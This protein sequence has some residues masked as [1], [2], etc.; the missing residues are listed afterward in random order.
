MTLP[1]TIAG[2]AF[3]SDSAFRQVVAAIAVEGDLVLAVGGAVRNAL[4]GLPVADVD[5]ATTALPR[6]VMDRARAAGLKAVP[7]GIDHGT[8]TVVADHVGFEVT[9]L[10]ADVETDGRRATVA[11]TR[12]I[13]EDAGRRDFTMNAIYA[14]LDGRLTDPTGGVA[15][16][17][18]RR[19]RF[20]GD[21]RERIRE[22]YLRI[23]R[24][25]RFHA[26]LGRGEP[27]AT[28]LAACV[29]LAAGLDRLSR[30]RIGQESRKL[31]VADGAGPTIALMARTGVLPHV[32]GETGDPERFARLAGLAEGAGLA[33]DPALAIAGVADADTDALAERLR[34]SRAEQARVAALRD[35]ASAL[36]PAPSERA[37]RL[38][39]YRSGN[40]TTAG[41]LL[42]AAAAAAAP[43]SPFHAIAARWT[44]PRFPV[45]GRQLMAQG[46]P[47]GPELGRRLADLEADWIIQ[48]FGPGPG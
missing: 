14:D 38:C 19:V 46:V 18:A 20:I 48:T 45:T 15:D 39:V 8:V 24:F 23:L 37:V 44:A 36:G 12:D 4:M 25:F 6:T 34:L 9:T 5:V 17:L 11:Y 42:L 22:D 32:L 26:A 40:D 43:L 3:L 2:A 29:D 16:A 13:D 10:R 41:G 28:G 1:G 31:L 47:A 35:C 30:E 7:T 27:D 33:L 21:A